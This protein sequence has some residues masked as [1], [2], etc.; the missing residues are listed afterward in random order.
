MTE[1]LE[2]VLYY[3]EPDSACDVL[4]F[5][6]DPYPGRIGGLWKLT[7]TESPDVADHIG[8]KRP[9]FYIVRSC[10]LYHRRFI[11]YLL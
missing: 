1:V 3:P 8:E 4:V 9:I 11:S 6:A 10:F 2:W 5:T 7:K